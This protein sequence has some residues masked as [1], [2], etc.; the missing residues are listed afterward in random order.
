M[1]FQR[2]AST[3]DIYKKINYTHQKVRQEAKYHIVTIKEIEQLKTQAYI[4]ILTFL[5]PLSQH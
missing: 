1:K 3:A 4:Q 5:L 2:H